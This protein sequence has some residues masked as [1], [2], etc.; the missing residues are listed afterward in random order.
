MGVSQHIISQQSTSNFEGSDLHLDALQRP[1]RQWPMVHHNELY[2]A[3]SY[4]SIWGIFVQFVNIF[5]LI[6]KVHLLCIEGT[7]L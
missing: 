6:L 7:R 3:C 2:G 5:C 4:V 1:H